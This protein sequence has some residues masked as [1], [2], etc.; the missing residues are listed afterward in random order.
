MI[1]SFYSLINEARP[2]ADTPKKDD[3]ADE[4]A[5]QLEQ[6]HSGSGLMRYIPKTSPARLELARKMLGF[7]HTQDDEDDRLPTGGSAPLG[8]PPKG[9]S[10]MGVTGI[11]GG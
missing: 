3:Y 4:Y 9:K 7:A 6:E 8:D 5:I 2:P 1:I 11:S 10:S